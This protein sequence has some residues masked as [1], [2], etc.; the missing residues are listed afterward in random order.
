[1]TYLDGL[2]IGLLLGVMLG[3]YFGFEWALWTHARPKYRLSRKAWLRVRF[4]YWRV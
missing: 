2:L 3:A 4:P 1:M